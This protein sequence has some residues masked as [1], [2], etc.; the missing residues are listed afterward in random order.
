[1]KTPRLTEN[2]L[3]D[4]QLKFLYE[5]ILLYCESDRKAFG[6][7]EILNRK[8][9]KQ[10]GLQKFRFVYKNYASRMKTPEIDTFY[11]H[12]ETSKKKKKEYM[13]VVRNWF[14][15][16]RNAFAHNYITIDNGLFVMKDFQKDSFKQ[17]FY[18][19]LSS[20]ELFIQL[21]HTVKE[22]INQDL[23]P[24]Q[25]NNNSNEMS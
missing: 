15:H 18:V 14:F 3:S 10:E 16:I 20:F 8:V 21:V 19:K 5:E 2:I 4:E 11:F 25:E 6:T 23:K 22:L 17:T 1:M 9:K 12:A 24:K 7:A 13:D